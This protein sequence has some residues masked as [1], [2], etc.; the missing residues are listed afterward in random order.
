[1]GDNAQFQLP[2]EKLVLNKKALLI[3]GA[4]LVVAVAL[5][6]WAVSSND[7]EKAA[8]R[9]AERVAESAPYLAERFCE[10][11]VEAQLKSPATADFSNTTAQVNSDGNYNVAG[12]VD[13]ENSF[14]AM[15]RTGFKCVVEVNTETTKLLDISFTEAD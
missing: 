5:I 11:Q 7:P 12:Q 8:Q 15:L 2:G 13:S 9:D 6:A 4:V 14:G 1:M 10:R 3:W